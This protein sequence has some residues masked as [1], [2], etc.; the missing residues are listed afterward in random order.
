MQLRTACLSL[1]FATL[2]VG[3]V[4]AQ[5]QPDTRGAMV[6]Q[7]DVRRWAILVGVNDYAIIGNLNYCVNDVTIRCATNYSSTAMKTNGCSA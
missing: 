4:A 6:E 3:Q 7:Q 5:E 2:L 1:I